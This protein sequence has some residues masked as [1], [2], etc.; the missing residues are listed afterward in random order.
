MACSA[1][2]LA[3][4]LVQPSSAE[5][6]EISKFLLIQMSR[7]QSAAFCKS[8]S[9]TQCMGFTEERCMELAE[10]AINQCLAPLPDKIDPTKLE[11]SVLED[12][13]KG[14]YKEAGFEEE[15]AKQCFLET[16]EKP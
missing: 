4:S 9:Y 6:N 15:K 7:D 5:A 2:V 3:T 14:V 10:K 1:F 11:N 12:C 13:P 16:V 8:E